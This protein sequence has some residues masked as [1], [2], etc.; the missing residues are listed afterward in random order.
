[1]IAAPQGMKY[2]GL[3]GAEEI[4]AADHQVLKNYYLLKGKP[5]SRMKDKDDFAEVVAVGKAFLPVEQTQ[6]KLA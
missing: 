2:D 6:C 1:M 4:R 3:T 5:K